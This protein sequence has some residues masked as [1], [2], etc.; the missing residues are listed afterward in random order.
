MPSLDVTPLEFRDEPDICKNGVLGVS[1]GE[2]IMMLALFILIQ[3]QSVTDEQTD[4]QTDGRTATPTI[5][6]LA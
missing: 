1:V 3:Y 4:G 2:E 5:P 6:A